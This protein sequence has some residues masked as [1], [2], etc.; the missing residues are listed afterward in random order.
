[1]TTYLGNPPSMMVA[2]PQGASDPGSQP[3]TSIAICAGSGGS[4]FSKLKESVD[5]LLTGELTHHEALA[6][7][8]QGRS[9]ICV[10]HSNSE[11][12]YLGAVMK[13]LLKAEIEK[14]W[15]AAR[16]GNEVGDQEQGVEVEVSRADRDPFGYVVRSV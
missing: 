11:R 13:G 2:T 12:A 10:N 3:I 4:V 14:T 6:A 16:E 7:V 1:M 15:G 8:E 9:V 5:L